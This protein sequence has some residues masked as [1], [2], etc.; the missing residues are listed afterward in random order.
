MRKQLFMHTDCGGYKT[1]TES[2]TFLIVDLFCGAG[3]TTTGFD[4]AMRE[5]SKVAK[6]IACVNHDWKAIKSHWQNHPD[7][8]HFTEDIRTLDLTELI[9][10]CHYWQALYPDAKL[11]L[12]ASLECTNF[13]KAKGGQPRDADS[14]T[15]ADHLDRYILAL[16]PDYVQIENVVEFMSWGPLDD[17]GKPVSRKSGSDWMRWRKHIDSFGYRNE[18][19]ELNSADFG[20]YTSRNR[21]FGCFAKPGLPIV[22]PEATHGKKP[23]TGSLFGANVHKWKAVKDVLDFEDEGESI[24]ARKKEL[25]PK[26]L[27][28][29]YAGLI[30]YV[31]GGK[32]AFIQQTYACASNNAANYP[33]DQVGRS[34]TTR[35]S[36]QL[37][38]ACFLSTYNSGNAKNRNSSINEPCKSVLTANTHAVVNSSF[39]AKNFSGNPDD[40]VIPVTGP[41]GTITTIPQ[42]SLV[43]PKFIVQRNT[44]N[45]DGRVVSVDGPA[46]TLTGTAGNQDLVQPKFIMNYHHSSDVNSIEQPSPTLTTRDKLAS[47]TCFLHSYYGNGDNNKSVEEPCATLTT[48]DRLVKIWLD[49][50]YG[51]NRNHQSIEQPAGVVM[52]NDKHQLVQTSWLDRNFSSGGQHSSIEEPAGSVLSIPKL[53]LVK[54]DPFVLNGNF[55]HSSPVKDPAPTLTSSR[56]HH[57]IVNPSHGGH[58]SSTDAPCPVIIARQDKAP[59][60]LLQVDYANVFI[61]VYEDEPEIMVN[62]KEFMCLYGISDIKMRMLKVLELLKIQ[63]FPETYQLYG[64]QSD[65]KKFIGNSVVPHVVKAWCEAM[66]L[67]LFEERQAA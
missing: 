22:W 19:K 32:D 53:N 15:L 51:G 23:A 16:N 56:H 14:R 4:M 44:G 5:G 66:D 55:G 58:S 33:V 47:V 37:V 39:I 49:K 31:A 43:Q 35:E 45:P 34:V 54:T 13:S 21:L 59:L 6:V 12:W 26:T 7:V 40:K 11:I 46:R 63:G 18:W 57:Y 52:S 25:S 64:N 8:K 62:I 48:K 2:P 27:E 41:A 9:A 38:K 60:Y 65:Q 42:Q 30:K 29:I 50:T 36:S 24:F 3:G 17:N 61:P 10:I 1:L 28:R 20:A 67:R